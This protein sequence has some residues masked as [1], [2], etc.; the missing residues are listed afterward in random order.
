MITGARV[1]KTGLAVTI[2]IYACLFLN[3]E[4]TIFAAT[5]AVLNLQPSL[6]KSLH[7]AL[8]QILIHAVSISIAI[9][10]GL[11]IGG[12]PLT[13]GLSTIIVILISNRLKW[14]SG[15]SGGIMATIFVLASPPD[16]FLNH[17]FIRSLSI[18]IG[19]VSALFVNTI[20]APP[21]YEATLS[22]K[23]LELNRFIFQTFSQAV[24][25]YMQLITLTPASMKELDNE[26]T[27]HFQDVHHYYDLYEHDLGSAQNEN[28]GTKIDFYQEYLN[29]NKGLWQRTKDIFFLSRE[30]I[31]RRDKAN[32]DPTVSE[33]FQQIL[34]LINGTLELLTHHNQELQKKVTG[35]TPAHIE[36]PHIWRKLDNILDQWHNNFSND[37]YYH[38]ALIEVALITYKIR[39]AAKEAV[40]LLDINGNNGNNKN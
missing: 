31:T 22:Q 6:G 19:V 1:F 38:H 39:W 37:N 27:K 5:A 17:A 18:F 2:S 35:E 3:I 4:T 33:E 15:M 10:F 12:H 36:E 28:K 21:R 32:H 13:M 7:T 14:H 29:Y 9:I 34:Q 24:Q 20:I 30:R 23:L 26:A 40:H 16:Q 25:N 8:E 11:T